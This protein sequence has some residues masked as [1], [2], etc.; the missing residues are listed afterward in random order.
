MSSLKEAD[1]CNLEN[2][3][4]ILNTHTKILFCLYLAHPLILI[5]VD[6]LSI[7]WVY[8]LYAWLYP[9]EERHKS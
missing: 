5:F 9:M 1:F 8:L 3:V 6:Y 7:Y 4:K 2:T